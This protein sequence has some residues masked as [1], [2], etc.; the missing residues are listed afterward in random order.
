MRGIGHNCARLFQFESDNS[1]VIGLTLYGNNIA[2]VST[3]KGGEMRTRGYAFGL[4]CVL[5]ALLV[6]GSLATVRADSFNYQM[7]ATVGQITSGTPEVILGTLT[8]QFTIDTDGVPFNY[9]SLGCSTGVEDTYNSPSVASGTLFWNPNNGTSVPLTVNSQV[10]TL[11]GGAA[12]PGGTTTCTFATG[13]Y[14]PFLLLVGEPGETN[15]FIYVY[16][17]LGGQLTVFG[18][19]DGQSGLTIYSPDGA[20]TFANGFSGVANPVPEPATFTLFLLGAIMV[21]LL[22]RADALKRLA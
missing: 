17:T 22:G 1:L 10:Y 20:T 8:G 18:S 21:W 14:C 4:V 7:N 15:G 9:C 6:Q 2:Q 13:T 12:T 5:A 19:V 16:G 3:N 11:A